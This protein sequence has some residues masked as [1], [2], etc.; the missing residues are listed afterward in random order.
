MRHE[1]YLGRFFLLQIL[2]R[3]SGFRYVFRTNVRRFPERDPRSRREFFR[4]GDRC[5]RLFSGERFSRRYF[6]VFLCGRHSLENCH[7]GG[8]DLSVELHLER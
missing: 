7:S 4:I 8:W 5:V 1:L 2:L 6:R 3:R